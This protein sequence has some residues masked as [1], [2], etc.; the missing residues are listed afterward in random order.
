VALFH[1][2]HFKSINDML[3]HDAGD[4]ALCRFARILSQE[5]SSADLVARMGGEEFLAVL[6]ATDAEGAERFAEHVATTLAEPAR[7]ELPAV[8]ASVGIASLGDRLTTPSQ[9]LTAADGA[10]YRAKE[11]G[12]NRAVIAGD[13]PVADARRAA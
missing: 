10:L 5:R 9:L 13:Q 11:L 8:T 4:A 7:G 2:D 6:S 1:L 12:R 3:G